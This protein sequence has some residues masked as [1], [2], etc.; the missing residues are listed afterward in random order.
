MSKRSGIIEE[1]ETAKVYGKKKR[2]DFSDN[3]SQKQGITRMISSTTSQRAIKYRKDEMRELYK[4]AR[5]NMH[6]DGL[7]KENLLDVLN[8][9]LGRKQF[10]MTVC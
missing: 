7:K 2:Q 9:I 1:N 6:H 3:L 8:A 5:D 10:K 4:K